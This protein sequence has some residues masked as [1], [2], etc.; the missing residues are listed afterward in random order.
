M[1]EVLDQPLMRGR[2]GLNIEPLFMEATEIANALNTI[3]R[4]EGYQSSVGASLGA[5]VVILALQ[6]LHKVVVFALDEPTLDLREGY[7]ASLD[8]EAT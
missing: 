4:A 7:A 6:G 3:L 8:Q 5:S 1:I 2:H